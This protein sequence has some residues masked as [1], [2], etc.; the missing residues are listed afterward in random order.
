MKAKDLLHIE[1]SEEAT[2][3][4]DG[5]AYS[6]FEN[7]GVGVRATHKKSGVSQTIAF[8]SKGDALEL[9]TG[10]W[11]VK[12]RFSWVDVIVISVINAAVRAW[13]F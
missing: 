7:D 12:E 2:V 11:Y 8:D 5:K 1:L 9:W 10:K 6:L 4:L 3:E 13:L